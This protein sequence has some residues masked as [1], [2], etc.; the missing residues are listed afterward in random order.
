M[1]G[2][3]GLPA[4][5]QKQVGKYAFVVTIPNPHRKAVGGLCC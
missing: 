3:H 1:R 5:Q 2:V 4:D